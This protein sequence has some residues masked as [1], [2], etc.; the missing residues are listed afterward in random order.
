MPFHRVEKRPAPDEV[1]IKIS[2]G[3]KSAVS[4]RRVQ[5][6]QEYRRAEVRPAEKRVVVAEERV[7]QV[8]GERKRYQADKKDEMD[9]RK[10]IPFRCEPAR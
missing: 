7:R 3:T 4:A 5:R 6:R 8:S 9:R 2:E 1:Q 10:T